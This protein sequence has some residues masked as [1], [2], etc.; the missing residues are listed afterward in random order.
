MD[1]VLEDAG[2]PDDAG[3]ALVF[4]IPQT[5]KRVDFIVTGTFAVAARCEGHCSSQNS[6]LMSGTAGEIEPPFSVP[7]GTPMQFSPA[8]S[9]V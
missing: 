8:W 5:G 9:G 4:N 1:T 7:I 6:Q 3:V 2:I